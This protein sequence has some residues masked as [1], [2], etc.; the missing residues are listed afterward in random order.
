ANH[1]NEDIR[2]LARSGIELIVSEPVP[3]IQPLVPKAYRDL[4]ANVLDTPVVD[5]RTLR[6]DDLEDFLK[7]ADQY[8]AILEGQLQNLHDAHYGFDTEDDKYRT[9]VQFYLTQI[10]KLQLRVNALL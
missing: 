3:G 9:Q 10:N 2:L 5:L 6:A 8:Y 7:A 4:F 1:P